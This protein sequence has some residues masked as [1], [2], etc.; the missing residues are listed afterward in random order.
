LRSITVRQGANIAENVSS[1]SFFFWVQSATTNYQN[2]HHHRHPNPLNFAGGC[3]P[4]G[5]AG[6]KKKEQSDFPRKN[7]AFTVRDLQGSLLSFGDTDCRGLAEHQPFP[8][9]IINLWLRGSSIGTSYLLTVVLI[10]I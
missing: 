8:K 10:N 5:Y 9:F 3:R 4:M 2:C 1:F 7:Q 6:D